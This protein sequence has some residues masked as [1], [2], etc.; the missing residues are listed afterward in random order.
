MGPTT[1]A[2]SAFRTIKERHHHIRDNRVSDNGEPSD[3]ASDADS[4][5]SC[6]PY[7]R[8]WDGARYQDTCTASSDDDNGEPGDTASA[9]ANALV[10]CGNK[11]P[12]GWHAK[13]Q[14]AGETH[15]SESEL[16]IDAVQ[17]LAHV[18]IV[19]TQHFH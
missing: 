8:W 5:D 6:D 11:I 1:A 13:A 3:T 19:A 7:G 10:I 14:V 12:F 9:T 2:L 17:P 16:F 4:R 15:T 18:T